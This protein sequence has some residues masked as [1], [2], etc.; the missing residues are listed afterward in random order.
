MTREELNS[1]KEWFITTEL[2]KQ[3]VEEY[4]AYVVF[5]GGS[6]ALGTNRETSDIDIVAYIPSKIACKKTVYKNI[7]GDAYQDN[8][9]VHAMIYPLDLII[10]QIKF[11]MYA[12]ESQS[13]FASLC[14][15]SCLVDP[16]NIIYSTDFGK[17]VFEFLG[18]NYRQ[19]IYARCCT[20]MPK[21]KLEAEWMARNNDFLATSA[22]NYY[23]PILFYNKLH[24]IDDISLATKIKHEGSVALTDDEKHHIIDIMKWLVEWCSK[25]QDG[26]T[27]SFLYNLDLICKEPE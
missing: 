15:Y 17:T 8:L 5:L 16:I 18:N 10:N 21:Y 12:D 20:E 1:F 27:F 23:Y 2:Y 3:I 7:K 26:I 25:N 19:L 24:D 13:Y 9:T 22:V 14:A 6:R 4:K 11:Y